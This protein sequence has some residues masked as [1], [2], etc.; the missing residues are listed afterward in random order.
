M[1]DSCLL[2]RPQHH[3]LLQETKPAQQNSSLWGQ[4]AQGQ[5]V[6]LA[7]RGSITNTTVASIQQVRMAI[8]MFV[9]K[10]TQPT[11]APRQQFSC[12]AGCRGGWR[13]HQWFLA[14]LWC[15]VCGTCK[16]NCNPAA[17]GRDCLDGMQLSLS[18]CKHVM[19]CLQ[20]T[21]GHLWA[22]TYCTVACLLLLPARL[23]I[24]RHCC[25]CAKNASRD[26]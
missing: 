20:H 7:V 10:T 2:C 9:R 3:R 11:P 14:G 26:Q 8:S 23:I 5:Q 25:E 16:C 6:L 15:A 19:T 21:N 22:T 17:A 13:L 24:Q 4:A 12:S 1:L 18:S